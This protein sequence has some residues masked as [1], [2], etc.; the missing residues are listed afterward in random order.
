M[1]FYRFRAF[2]VEGHLMSSKWRRL[3][4]STADESIL[5]HSS[6]IRISPEPPGRVYMENEGDFKRTCTAVPPFTWWCQ[7]R[8][9]GMT[10]RL[11]Q[12][13][14]IFSSVL[15]HHNAL[16]DCQH[17]KMIQMY[18]P[19]TFSLKTHFT[20]TDQFYLELFNIYWMNSD[21]RDV[22]KWDWNW[23]LSYV[24]EKTNKR[25]GSIANAASKWMVPINQRILSFV[26]LIEAR[27]REITSNE[28]IRTRA[29]PST[30]NDG[31]MMISSQLFYQRE[32]IFSCLL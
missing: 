30:I 21:F 10:H 2:V 3:C 28:K 17:F 31:N 1:V 15:R 20:A 26:H 13:D 25:K 12:I 7:T 29:H 8:S 6:S 4:Q 19:S 24:N 18:T 32:H 14:E 11:S 5:A 27:F 16:V 22:T 23:V 9:T